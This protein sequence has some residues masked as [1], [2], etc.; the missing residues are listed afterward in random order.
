MCKVEQ[1]YWEKYLAI[2]Q[3]F[4]KDKQKSLTSRMPS[5]SKTVAAKRL[6]LFTIMKKDELVELDAT[7]RVRVLKG[8]DLEGKN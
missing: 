2:S 8:R 6:E 1:S 5:D 3:Y 4:F 7:V